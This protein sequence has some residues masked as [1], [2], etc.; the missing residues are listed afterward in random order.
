MNTKVEQIKEQIQAL[1]EE[2]S[3][4]YQHEWR[5]KNIDKV[6]EYDR[7]RKRKEREK[8]KKS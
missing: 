2:K 1:R 5:Q 7:I 6:R 8:I 3:R 4:I